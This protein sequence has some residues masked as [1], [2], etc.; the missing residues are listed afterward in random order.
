[1]TSL[2]LDQ[3]T[4]MKLLLSMK[5]ES[6][7]RDRLYI[8][9]GL[10]T[11]MRIGEILALRWKDLVEE[12]TG[13]AKKSLY[14][15]KGKAKREKYRYISLHEKLRN[16][17]VKEYRRQGRPPVDWYVFRPTRGAADFLSP[18]SQNGI[19][20]MLKKRLKG[21]GY[22]VSRVSSH[23][24][25]KTWAI[26]YY[27]TNNG[28]GRGL[29]RTMQALG[30]QNPGT[31]MKYMGLTEAEINEGIEKLDYENQ[32]EPIGEHPGRSMLEGRIEYKGACKYAAKYIRNIDLA[33]SFFRDYLDAHDVAPDDCINLMIEQW[34]KEL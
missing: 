17:I 32:Y 27:R 11:A 16:E 25:R 14:Y 31:T 21:I 26:N 23:T 12:E 7:G 3:K 20:Q 28:D 19:R 15:K 13:Y 1:M 34:K 18:M 4:V 10:Y 29:I 6:D 22:D 5:S 9:T 2:P 30:H 24:L 33:K 8:K